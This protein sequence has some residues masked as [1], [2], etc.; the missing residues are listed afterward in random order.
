M[1]KKKHTVVILLFEE[2]EVLDFA[3]PFEVFSVTAELSGYT[4]LDVVTV[5]KTGGVIRA[6]NGLRVIPDHS[7]ELVQH[8]DILIIPGG[9]GSKAMIEDQI[10]LD[11][12]K[13][14]SSNSQVTMSVC[15]GARILAKLGYL[16]GKE[17]A[18]H[19]SVY[20]DVLQLTHNGK[21][22]RDSRFVDLGQIMTAA[23]VAAGIDLSLHI[24]QK[25]FGKEVKERTA[26]YMEY[27]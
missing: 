27:Q 1:T 21:A 4:L 16:D 8:A 14:L 23:G 19:Q 5:S 9:D 20:E 22:A 26:K 7:L 17:F 13:K 25:I 11:W 6:K 18:T 3:G 15:S 24:V 2:V 10:V 12:I